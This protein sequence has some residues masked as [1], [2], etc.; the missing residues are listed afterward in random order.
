MSNFKINYGKYTL[1][2][3]LIVFFFGNGVYKYFTSYN[4][5]KKRIET[6]EKL[7]KEPF[8]EDII[9]LAD[10]LPVLCEEEDKLSSLFYGIK[11]FNKR[12]DEEK[13]TLILSILKKIPVQ[14][15]KTKPKNIFQQKLK[16]NLS[17]EFKKNSINH[18][19]VDYIITLK[20]EN[21][22]KSIED[23]INGIKMV[24]RNCDF[25][26]YAKEKLQKMES[27]EITKFESMLFWEFIEDKNVILNEKAVKEI[28]SAI[29][30]V[31]SESNEYSTYYN[32][33]CLN[34]LMNE[35]EMFF[36]KIAATKNLDSFKNL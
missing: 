15:E 5:S 27:V 3:S 35:A 22:P 17:K 1:M 14:L 20:N 12:T 33:G 28:M 10:F 32:E 36:V 19:T 9:F 24:F 34:I 6:I 18:L 8:Q 7:I 31:A 4:I 25:E 21:P 2:I 30:S 29:H 26:S 13:I 11:N 16:D 23:L